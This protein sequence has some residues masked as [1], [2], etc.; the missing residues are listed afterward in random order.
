MKARPVIENRI[1][2][3]EECL[4]RPQLEALQLARLRALVERVMTVPGSR[5]RLAAA[6]R[7]SE[8]IRTLDDI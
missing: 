1:W 3:P 6:G 5:V 2:Q 8:S 4:P 7:D